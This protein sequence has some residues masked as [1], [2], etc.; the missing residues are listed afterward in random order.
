MVSVNT[1]YSLFLRDIHEENL[2]LKDS[3]KEQSELVKKLSGMNR[4]KISVEKIS[5]LNNLK[6]FLSSREKIPNNLKKKVFPMK[7][8]DKI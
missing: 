7:N 5:F 1:C 4:G 2:S 3:H 8:L 6:L